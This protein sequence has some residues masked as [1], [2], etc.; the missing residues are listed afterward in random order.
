MAPLRNCFEY[1][2]VLDP[3]TEYEIRIQILFLLDLI[4]L[5][6]YFIAVHLSMV[7]ECVPDCG[8]GGGGTV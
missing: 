5:H 4:C 2:S 6:V 8:R 1:G 3:Y 7:R